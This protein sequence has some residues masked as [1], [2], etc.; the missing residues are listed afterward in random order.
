MRFPVAVLRETGEI[1]PVVF[2]L[3]PK[4]ASLIEDMGSLEVPLS[5]AQIQEH[6]Q[7]LAV[8]N[9]VD[10]GPQRNTALL[11]RLRKARQ[12]IHLVCSDLSEASSVW[13]SARR[14]PPSGS[15][16]TSTSSRATSGMFS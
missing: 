13:N 2:V 1:P 12:W 10:P 9:Q 7:R 5:P 6:A 14:R 3:H 11:R 16:T 4:R 15:S 8:D